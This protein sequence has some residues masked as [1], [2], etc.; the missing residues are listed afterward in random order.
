[1]KELKEKYVLVKNV[2]NNG[3]AMP[4][5]NVLQVFE[6]EKSA[7]ERLKELAYG[8]L[9]TMTNRAR[10][11]DDIDV[12][13]FSMFEFIAELTV[14]KYYLNLDDKDTIRTTWKIYKTFEA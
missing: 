13:W 4:E 3:C 11:G 9:S 12:T 2:Y 14:D 1:M 8:A 10:T 7:E 6:D 5:T